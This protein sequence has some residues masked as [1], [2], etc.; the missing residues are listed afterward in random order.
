MSQTLMRSTSPGTSDTSL[1]PL[2]QEIKNRLQDVIQPPPAD[3]TSAADE[4]AHPFAHFPADLHQVNHVIVEIAQETLLPLWMKSQREQETG[5]RA[6]Y[7]SF[8][9]LP[10]TQTLVVLDVAGIQNPIRSALRELGYDDQKVIEAEPEPGLGNG[11]LGRLASCLMTSTA[12]CD[13]PAMGYGINYAE[14]FQLQTFDAFGRPVAEPD[15][16]ERDRKSQHLFRESAPYTVNLFGHY[17]EKNG[18]HLWTNTTPVWA[19]REDFMI[20]GRTIDEGDVP[21]I[22][23]KRLWSVR[24]HGDAFDDRRNWLIEGIS[25]RLYPADDTQDEKL[26]RLVQQYFF[27]S[28]SLKDIVAR[29][30][31]HNESLHNLAETTAIQLNDTHPVIAIPELM[32][33]MVDGPDEDMQRLGI[34]WPKMKWGEAKQVMQEVCFYTNHTKAPEALETW[35]VE[36]VAEVLPRHMGIIKQLHEDEMHLVDSS[37]RKDNELLRDDV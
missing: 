9:F 21:M 30:M 26:R 22:N 27:V 1:S 31:K 36:Q 11:G 28:L 12:T 14:G 33:M 10:G 7:L 4:I 32:R 18:E 2:A 37:N 24:D 25:K 5:K 19:N 15:H 23:T 20:P 13:V 8:E 29:H 16:W 35:P 34:T 3:F 17:E 6:N